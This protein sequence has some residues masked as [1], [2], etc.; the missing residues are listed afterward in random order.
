MDTYHNSNICM[1]WDGNIK[2][3]DV[4]NCYHM[5]GG[6]KVNNN[7]FSSLFG[8]LISQPFCYVCLPALN[9]SLTSGDAI[10]HK[11]LIE[12]YNC[13]IK[14]LLHTPSRILA[15]PWFHDLETNACPTIE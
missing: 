15:F 1:I 12:I 8:E 9:I 2:I 7:S 6:C 3:G 4:T 13:I 5:L 11:F 10:P 14:I